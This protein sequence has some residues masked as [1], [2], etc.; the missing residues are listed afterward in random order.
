MIDWGR[1]G[2]VVQGQCVNCST[3]PDLCRGTWLGSQWKEACTVSFLL[4][5]YEC[6]TVCDIS[7]LSI[8]GQYH[9]SS[10]QHISRG[11][12]VNDS[13]SSFGYFGVPSSVYGRIV[14][15]TTHTPALSVNT[16]GSRHNFSTRLPR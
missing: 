9:S 10:L 8:C 15:S 16:G 11:E 4:C 13:N 5:T 7:M 6:S 1:L 14:L 12:S 3:L 2:D